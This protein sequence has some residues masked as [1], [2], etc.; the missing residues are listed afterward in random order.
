MDFLNCGFTLLF[1]TYIFVIQGKNSFVE[2]SKNN[3]V[4]LLK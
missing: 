1:L 2:V 4:G 3:F